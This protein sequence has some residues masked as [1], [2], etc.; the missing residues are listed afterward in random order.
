MTLAE[1]LLLRADLQKKLMSLRERIA[2]N[3]HRPDP[4]LEDRRGLPK[5]T[6]EVFAYIKHK[7]P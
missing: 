6:T 7:T 3:V 1:G 4:G 5:P 2:Q